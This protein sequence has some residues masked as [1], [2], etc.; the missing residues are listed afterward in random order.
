LADERRLCVAAELGG[1]EGRQGMLQDQLD[2]EEGNLGRDQ[3]LAPRRAL[4]LTKGGEDGLETGIRSAP[5]RG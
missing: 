1:R 2:R 5:W 4:L 3:F